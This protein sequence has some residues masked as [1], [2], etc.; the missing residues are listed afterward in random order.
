MGDY[1]TTGGSLRFKGGGGITKKKKKKS[2]KLD[3]S[4]VKATLEAKES[5]PPP[6]KPIKVIEKTAAELRFE[7]IQKKR[8]EEK[9]LKSA[10]KSHKEKVAE[11]NR[12]LEEMTEH[13]DIP[14]VGPG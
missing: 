11:L 14:K 4:K 2:E 7:E 3:P 8:Q 10:M 5:T 6:S 12:K 9:V 1:E 13:Y